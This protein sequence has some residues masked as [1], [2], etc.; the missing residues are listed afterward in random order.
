MVV[1][2]AGRR[3]KPLLRARHLANAPWG[4][5]AVPLCGQE[6]GPERPHTWGGPWWCREGPGLR[7]VASGTGVRGQRAC[8]SSPPVCLRPGPLPAWP[9]SSCPLRRRSPSALSSRGVS[10]PSGLPHLC[11]ELRA[12]AQHQ[13][14]P[15]AILLS[16]PREL[17]P[18]G[19]PY[20]AGRL[21]DSQEPGRPREPP[22][23]PEALGLWRRRLRLAELGPGRGEGEA[24]PA[25][26]RGG[27]GPPRAP[28]APGRGR[29][30]PDAAA[31]RRASLWSSCVVL[32]LLAVT[33]MSAVLAVTDRRSALFQILFAVFDSLEGFV[34]V[35]VHCILRREVGGPGPRRPVSP[36][37]LGNARRGIP[38]GASQALGVWGQSGRRRPR[39]HRTGP[40]P[41]DP[42]PDGACPPTPASGAHAPDVTPQRARGGQQRQEGG[43]GGRPAQTPP[44][45]PPARPS[46][47]C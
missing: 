42:Q 28:R 1:A 38:K 33:W 16:R 40:A 14:F 5:T 39:G 6:T 44:R 15:V 27:Q 34:I 29:A 23:P 12:P 36:R 8:Q 45:G 19:I 21:L 24:G 17:E 13:D 41:S 46:G 25:A 18:A 10:R 32:P 4:G 3:P 47:P 20:P 9:H 22:A 26:S 43:R 7:R 31:V 11:P 35:M 2:K 37:A 30:G